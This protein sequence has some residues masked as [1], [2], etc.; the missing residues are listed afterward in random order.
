[1]GT[2]RAL[3]TRGP[4]NSY[5]YIHRPPGDHRG[6]GLFADGVGFN[7]HPRLGVPGF[8]EEISLHAGS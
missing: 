1:M 7:A 3:I 2:D 6:K 5:A 8:V 4:F